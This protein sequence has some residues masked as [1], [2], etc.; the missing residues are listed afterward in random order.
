MKGSQN[1]KVEGYPS[2][3]LTHETAGNGFVENKRLT[4]GEGPTS[5]TGL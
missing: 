3:R 5:G 2:E 4:T 1:G